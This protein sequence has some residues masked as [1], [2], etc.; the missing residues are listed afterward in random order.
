MYSLHSW[1]PLY[2]GH[3]YLGITGVEFG[4]IKSKI[5]GSC[6][7][8]LCMVEFVDSYWSITLWNFLIRHKL[9][10]PRDPRLKVSVTSCL[11]TF[12]FGYDPITYDYK[13]VCIP[14][15]EFTKKHNSFIYST[16]KGSWSVITSPVI[17]FNCVESRACY[18]NGTLHWL[19]CVYVK[20]SSTI[21][22]T[23]YIVTFNMRTHV[24]DKILLPDSSS[25]AK[26][27]TIYNGALAFVSET[28]D[29]TSIWVMSEYNN[30]ASWSLIY[31][32]KPEQ[33]KTVKYLQPMANGDIVFNLK[34]GKYRVYHHKTGMF[35]DVFKFGRRYG[36]DM[37]TYVESL[38][39]LDTGSPCGR[40]MFVLDGKE[41]DFDINIDN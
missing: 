35:S 17:P 30:V 37:N 13:I 6:N 40:T 23:H 29:D 24:F 22:Y 41:H 26:Q 16:K 20:E 4:D 10:I 19:V 27:I 1:L 31:R 11:V 34:K 2:P 15:L 39:L 18:F 36:L 32:L 21:H 5:V 25:K 12:G 28:S 7:G 14:Y 8:I 33:S 38:E 9:T 3:G